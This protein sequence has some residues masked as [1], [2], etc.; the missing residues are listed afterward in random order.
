MSPQF[1]VIMICEGESEEKTYHL[2]S[3]TRDDGTE[4]DEAWVYR[5]GICH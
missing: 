2:R 5:E 3:D 1:S 4:K